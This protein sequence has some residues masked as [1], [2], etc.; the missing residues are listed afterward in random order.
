[1]HALMLGPLATCRRPEDTTGD[2]VGMA[3]QAAGQLQ[4][5][6]QT[7]SAPTCEGP[8]DFHR[9]CCGGTR[10]R[11]PPD[12]CC[13]RR[14]VIWSNRISIGDAVQAI[15]SIAKTI[16]ENRCCGLGREYAIRI[17]R[18]VHEAA[19]CALWLIVR[20][21]RKFCRCFRNPL[22]GRMVRIL[23]SRSID[24]ENAQLIIRH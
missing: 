11:R 2:L 14:E 7:Q 17:T 21:G 15:E 10:Q 22:A 6:V 1:V 19:N 23:I 5:T 9:G 24:K 13:C 20:Q 16:E 12:S 4:A 3:A 18:N 8:A